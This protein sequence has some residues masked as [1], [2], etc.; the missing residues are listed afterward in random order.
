MN[1]ESYYLKEILNDQRIRE[2][3][4]E[5]QRNYHTWQ[6][7]EACL[8]E[9]D[10]VRDKIHNHDAVFL[11]I[12]FHDIIYDP[13]KHDN[14]EESAKYALKFIDSIILPTEEISKVDLS[15]EV[16]RLI[17]A[18]KK[19]QPNPLSIRDDSK[20]FL[21][22][23]LSILGQ[24]EEIFDK[25]EDDI[26]KEYS[27]VPEYIYKIERTK[28]LESFI[29]RKHIFFTAHYRDKYEKWAWINLRRSID[30]LK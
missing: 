3:Y 30:K 14:E 16:I 2:R 26:R 6:H 8:K 21:D 17:I 28:I 4:S 9:L 19:H 13:T 29:Y 23:D 1:E 25:Y 20:Y 10:S 15:A 11:A 24:S 7:I 5:P 12:I 18:T 27:F 22:I